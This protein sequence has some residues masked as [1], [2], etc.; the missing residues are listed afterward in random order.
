MGIIAHAPFIFSNS[1]PLPGSHVQEKCQKLSWKSHVQMSLQ[2]APC[3]SGPQAHGIYCRGPP[4]MLLREPLG[5]PSAS[6][7]FQSQ[8]HTGMVWGVL[9][10]PGPAPLR[11][12]VELIWGGPRVSLSCPHEG[13]LF[14][15]AVRGRVLSSQQLACALSS[16]MMR[17]L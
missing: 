10:V 7:A 12:A 17:S 2:S 1:V 15:S 11:N 9:R 5:S 4:E 16:G 3:S 6:G 13:N 14:L 8:L